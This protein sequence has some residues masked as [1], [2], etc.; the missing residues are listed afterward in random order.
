MSSNSRLVLP[1][2]LGLA[3][4]LPGLRAEA[5][6]QDPPAPKEGGTPAT[7][8]PQEKTAEEKKAEEIKAFLKSYEEGLS[9]MADADAIAGIAKLKGYYV[10]PK[11]EPEQKKAVLKLFSE[12]VIKVR[13]KDAY[14]EAAAKALGDMG[15][16]TPVAM[17]QYLV[18]YASNQKIQITSVVRAGLGALGKIASGK[19]SDVKFL[20]ELLKGKDEFI[21]DA[22][23][24]LGGYAKAPGAI[25]HDVFEE[26]LKMSEGVY[27]K[28][29][30]NDNAAK[31]KWNIWGTEVIEAMKAVSHQNF[32]DPVK[33][34]AWLNDK[35]AN[36]GK[37]PKA[38]ADEPE[39]P[40]QK[41]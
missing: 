5:A 38:W 17:L 31:R 26:L 23:R 7:P 6:P 24:A 21:G 18:N 35:G 16:D 22:A 28:S 27:S 34:R 4:V 40:G 20:T 41:N 39:A 8:P 30:A 12:K 15:G 1:A 32:A 14:L 37:N 11:V 3:L 9:K 25:R 33:F 19:P 10:D 13:G 36:G 29:Q 2:L